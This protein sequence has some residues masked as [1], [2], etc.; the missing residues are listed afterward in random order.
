MRGRK[1]GKLVASLFAESLPELVYFLVVQRVLSQRGKIVAK[2]YCH[3]KVPQLYAI[4]Q[5]MR[6]FSPKNYV[7]VN[8]EAAIW[9]E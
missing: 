1:H 2:A 8:G 9:D 6:A 4:N 5:N 7:G 3:E